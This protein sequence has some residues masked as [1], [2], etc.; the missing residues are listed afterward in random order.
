MLSLYPKFLQL[1]LLG[2]K[3]LA[4]TLGVEIGETITLDGAA[5]FDRAVLNAAIAKVYADEAEASSVEDLEG[6][7][8]SVLVDSGR[9]PPSIR[10]SKGEASYL[11]AGFPWLLPKADDRLQHL[12]GLRSELAIGMDALAPFRT[13]LSRRTLKPAEIDALQEIVERSPIHTA[14]KIAGDIARGEGD[15]ETIAPSHAESYAAFVGRDPAGDLESF[16]DTILPGI[17][18]AWLDWDNFEGAKMALLSCGQGALGPATE[19]RDLPGDHLVGLADWGVEDADLL[20][21]VAIIEVGLPNL[22]RVPALAAPLSR[23][24]EQLRD[25]QPKAERSRAKLL[26]A[27]FLTVEAELSRTQALAHLPPFQRRIATLAQASLFDRTAHRRV[28]IEGFGKWALEDRGRHF[29]VQQLVDMRSEPRWHP[30]GASAERLDAELMGRIR[31][32]AWANSDTIVGTELEELLLGAGAGAITSRVQFPGSFLPG[33]AEGAD[34]SAPATP[35][36]FE[37]ILDQTLGERELTPRS[38]IAL[39]NLSATFRVG[40][41]RIDRAIQLIRSASYHFAVDVSADQRDVLIDGL[42]KVAAGT[43]R[44]DLARDVRTMLRRQRMDGSAQLSITS[45]FLTCL[46]A[47]AAHRDLADWVDFVGDCAMEAANST[48]REDEARLLHF[49]VERLCQCEP[50]VRARGGGRALATLQLMLKE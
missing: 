45:E 21:K 36:E 17:V 20:S 26:M 42:A 28:D 18:R 37:D 34:H 11:L 9:S 3:T 10:L 27:G 12:E 35:Q 4:D 1:R 13:L 46:T 16:R 14:R 49:D 25:M 7:Q 31:N 50:L 5:S 15:P 43:R 30:E 44:A 40:D 47:A 33:P 2:E 29:Y 48:S 24:V 23:L 19:L 32:A 39:V 8:W 41:D 38:V 22:R 6:K